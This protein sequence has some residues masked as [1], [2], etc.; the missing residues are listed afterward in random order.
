MYEINLYSTLFR[1]TFE[2]NTTWK[3]M[4]SHQNFREIFHFDFMHLKKLERDSCANDTLSN[5]SQFEASTKP[6]I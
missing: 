4:D 1:E 5:K 2:L 6:T 3:K